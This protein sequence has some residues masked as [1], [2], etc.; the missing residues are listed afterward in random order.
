MAYNDH[1]VKALEGRAEYLLP[2]EK[3]AQEQTTNT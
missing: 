1:W 2:Y 3:K